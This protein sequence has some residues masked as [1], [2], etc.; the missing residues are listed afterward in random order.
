VKRALIVTLCF[1]PIIWAVFAISMMG[2]CHHEISTQECDASKSI[3][4]RTG[5]M[6][7]AIA[8]VVVLARPLFR[9]RD[10]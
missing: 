5:M 9:R 2:D 1:L 10:L 7:V 3:T 6:L 4:V 8:F